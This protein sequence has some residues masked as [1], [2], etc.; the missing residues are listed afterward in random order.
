MVFNNPRFIP[1][2]VASASVV[3][4]GSAAAGTAAL[5]KNVSE[6]ASATL[7][8]PTGERVG[9]VAFAQTPNGVLLTATLTGL[10]PGEHGFH[11][12]QTGSCD[13]D[14]SAAGGHF[15]PAGAAHGILSADGAHA[16]DMP[17]INVGADGKLKI[18]VL[19]TQI[20]LK[21]SGDGYLFDDDGAAMLIHAGADD[22]SSQP[23]GD[24]GDRI[25]CGVI[26]K[27]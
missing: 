3:I 20:S 27:N 18:E 15:T 17:N 25:A 12:H 8:N 16:G 1:L 24:A 26:Q 14:F 7:K 2:I 6:R 21:E 9:S 23:S 19:N 11:I 10:P 4:A 5:Q 13:P 22:Y